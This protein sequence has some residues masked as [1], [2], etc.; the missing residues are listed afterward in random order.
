MPLTIKS[1]GEISS[2]LF[3]VDSDGDVINAGEL[4]PTTALSA[5][6]LNVGQIGGRRNLII[7]GAMQVAQRGN[8][9]N[10][11]GVFVADRFAF[12]TNGLGG[13][14]AVIAASTQSTIVP[15]GFA[16]ALKTNVTTAGS[17]FSA[18]NRDG[19]TTALEHQDITH[20][21][22]AGNSFTLSFWV[23]SSLATTYGVTLT[24]ADRDTSSTGDRYATSYT[25][26]AVNTWEKKTI[27]IPAP[28]SSRSG[29]SDNGTGI[30]IYWNLEMISG[31]S[32]S[33]A[34][35]NAWED[36]GVSYAVVSAAADTGWMSSTNDFYITGVQL[37]V[38]SV[39]T[40]FEHISYGE[41]LALCQRYYTKSYGQGVNPGTA[42]IDG[43]VGRHGVAGTATGGEIFT[44]TV[45][46]VEMRGVPTVLAYDTS[47]NSAKC[48]VTNFG[49]ADYN[50]Q[51]CNEV[52]IQTSGCHFQR[53]SGS[54]GCAITVHYTADAEL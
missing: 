48:N 23:R 50:N 28:T 9:T 27:T 32:R 5:T 54:S 18:D 37:E 39:A 22:D 47:G 7:N 41:S 19:F 20:L 13:A 43:S 46:K 45:F 52:H 35:A 17:G 29:G 3:T 24:L 44:S 15:S 12:Q 16:S 49:V 42:T 31:G 10:D 53:P 11:N 21:I 51:T 40:P 36:T 30:V 1:T 6:Y 33:S 4:Q 14:G 25:I 2:S 34:S 26:N 38:G 8:T